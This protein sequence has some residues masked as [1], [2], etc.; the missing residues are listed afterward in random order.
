MGYVLTGTQP[1][2]G[3]FEGYMVIISTYQLETQRGSPLYHWLSGP[4]GSMIFDHPYNRGDVR[5]GACE[6]RL[7]NMR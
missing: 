6:D 3:Q 4:Q 5:Q 1:P 2:A 7:H